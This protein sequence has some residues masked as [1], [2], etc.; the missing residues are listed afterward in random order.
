MEAFQ[1]AGIGGEILPPMDSVRRRCTPCQLSQQLAVP[2]AWPLASHCRASLVPQATNHNTNLA[3]TNRNHAVLGNQALDDVETAVMTVG[4]AKP[5][6]YGLVFDVRTHSPLPP[7]AR[8]EDGKLLV[9][10]PVVRSFEV[11]LERT[12]P[13]PALSFGG[14]ETGGESETPPADGLDAE[15]HAE[16]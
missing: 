9:A 13:R 8:V 14:A 3:R 5:Y 1:H 7:G 4:D 15:A 12:K 11:N 16:L 2:Y 6:P 10:M